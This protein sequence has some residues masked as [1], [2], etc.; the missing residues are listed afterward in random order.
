[1]ESFR[2]HKQLFCS[3]LI[4]MLVLFFCNNINVPLIEM[5]FVTVCVF[6]W[7]QVGK[8]SF[9]KAVSW[10]SSCVRCGVCV[11]CRAAARRLSSPS[12]PS[13]GSQFASCW[14]RSVRL[15]VH[16]CLSLPASSHICHGYMCAANAHIKRRQTTSVWI[17]YGLCDWPITI[18]CQSTEVAM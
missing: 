14:V 13:A 8:A 16:S 17:F 7:V 1:M 9:W 18:V 2:F 12:G 11:R 15:H 3:V 4:L 10:G 5:C 6:V